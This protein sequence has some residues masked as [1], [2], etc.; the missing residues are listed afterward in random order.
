MQKFETV[1]RI[2]LFLVCLDP[3]FQKRGHHHGLD[4][5]KTRHTTG[6][7]VLCVVVYD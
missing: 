2:H 4:V 6:E 7:A 5:S 1:R 3:V